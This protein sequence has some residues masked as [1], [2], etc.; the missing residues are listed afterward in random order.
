M[1]Q[2]TKL[3]EESCKQNESEQ[4]KKKS[5]QKSKELSSKNKNELFFDYVPGKKYSKYEEEERRIARL[6]LGMD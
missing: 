4:N 1:K 5:L 6:E 2:Q 3:K